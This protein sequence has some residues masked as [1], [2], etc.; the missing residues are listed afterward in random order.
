MKNKSLHNI[1]IIEQF[2]DDVKI[3][4]LNWNSLLSILMT[5]NKTKYFLLYQQYKDIMA[6]GEDKLLQKYAITI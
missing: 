5:G 3:N 6:G 4:S 2:K 1:D